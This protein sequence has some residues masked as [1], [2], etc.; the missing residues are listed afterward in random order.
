MKREV[1]VL[2]E[3]QESGPDKMSVW[4]CWGRARQEVDREFD[5]P[6]S[7]VWSRENHRFEG[8][9]HF[10]RFTITPLWLDSTATKLPKSEFV[11][12]IGDRS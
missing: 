11:T 3:R 4:P 8:Q 1:F 9:G 2:T 7:F 5:N 6:D 10:A 12:W